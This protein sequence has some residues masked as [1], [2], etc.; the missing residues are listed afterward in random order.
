MG[1]YDINT[2]K[3]PIMTSILSFLKHK[4]KTESH[5]HE[6]KL[7]I[8]DTIV[9]FANSKDCSMARAVEKLH[10]F[11]AFKID[12]VLN[13]ITESVKNINNEVAQ[14]FNDG[15]VLLNHEGRLYGLCKKDSN[16]W[17]NG[18]F[19]KHDIQISHTNALLDVIHVENEH[20]NNTPEVKTNA[21]LR[22]TL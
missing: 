14:K 13:T 7:S 16:L 3:D 15:S 17:E 18:L 10:S 22:M 4:E 11:Q 21:S 20:A 19:M 2:L 8:M 9:N 5:D 6:E 1:Y 12:D